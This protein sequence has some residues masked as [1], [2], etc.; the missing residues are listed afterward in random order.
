MTITSLHPSSRA[1]RALVPALGGIAALALAGCSSAASEPAGSSSPE[2]S[3]TSSAPTAAEVAAAQPRVVLTHEGG[4]TVLDGTTLEKVATLKLK[5]YNRINDAGDGRHVLISAQGG[6]RVLDAGA[7]ATSHGDH[8]HYYAGDPVLTDALW[9][10]ETPAHVVAHD[11]STVLFDDGTGKVKVV[12]SGDI[13]DPEAQVRTYAAPDAHHGVAVE[14]EDGAMLV[15]EGTED[16]VSSVLVV[17]AQGQE[18]ARTDDCPGVHGEGAAAGGAIG[19]GCQ[20][21]IVVWSG[22]ELRK[23]ASPDAFGQTEDQV[24]SEAS[25]VLLGDYRTDPEAEAPQTR[26][27]L[28]DTAAAS[29]R[30]VD[31]PAAYTF[32][33]LARGDA[34]EALVLG[35]DGALHV[36]DPASGQ[37]VRSIPVVEAWEVPED[38]QEARPTVRTHDGTAYVTEPAT[39]EVHAVDVES[40][41]IFTSVTLDVVPDE[42]VPVS[43]DAVE[44]ASAEYGGEDDGA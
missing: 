25:P 12:D 44:G 37:L 34:G 24:G 33:S 41:E 16:G 27:V 31:L 7:Y 3:A 32:R 14:R 38:W 5:G 23:I 13:A 8:D 21:G 20:D 11:G 39:N 28:A 4:F 6:F 29:M 43:G 35:T 26:V 22:D 9:P 10:A 17:D 42:I 40:G 18:I 2:S 30:V 36:I 15:T 1:R 19:V